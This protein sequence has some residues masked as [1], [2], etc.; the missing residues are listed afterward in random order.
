[1][2]GTNL[3]LGRESPVAAPFG[4][5]PSRPAS[6]GDLIQYDGEAPVTIIAPTGSGKGRDVLIPLLLTCTDPVITIDI[7]GELAAVTARRRREMGHR[8]AVFK[9]FATSGEPS[10]RIDPFELFDLPGSFLD[11]DAEMLAAILG[12]GHGSTKE[13]FW[14]DTASSLIS[15]LI[16][17]EQ[18]L[19]REDLRGF[20]F[21]RQHLYND[22]IEIEIAKIL[23]ACTAEQRGTFAY[24]ELAAYLQHPEYQT[25]PSVLSTART[26]MRALNSAPVAECL[27][28][29]TIHLQEVRD[30]APLDIFIVIPPEK[31]IS[32]AGLLRMLIGTLLT[33]IM[34]RSEIP[35]QRTLMIVDEAAQL[36]KEFAPL[37]TATTL[38]RGYG[39][40][41]VTAWQDLAQIKSRYEIDWPTLLNNSGAILAFGFGHYSAAKDAA[42]FLGLEPHELL[43]LKGD[44]AVLALRGDSP[45]KITRQNYLKD[46]MF[47]DL[48]DPNPYFR[49]KIL[50]R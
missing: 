2:Q 3:I 28:N 13:P 49:P 44:E 39:L 30:G 48:A 50:G 10:D 25:R 14:P 36:G 4:F 26:F 22:D 38:M 21:V 32:H 6:L 27:Q 12:E 42:E 43:K 18:M 46:T 40:R 17:M 29:P 24:Q 23:D 8:V 5:D 7:K 34:R 47:A 15:G 16:G 9:P 19:K 1:M 20:A 33:T 41:L 37:L 45:R 35:D 31:V 11:C